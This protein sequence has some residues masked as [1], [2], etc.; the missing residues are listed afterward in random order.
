[1]QEKIHTLELFDGTIATIKDTSKYK[2]LK[3][4]GYNF[5]FNKENGF[6]KMG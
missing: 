5:F 3:S 6:C 4:E 2:A 1:M